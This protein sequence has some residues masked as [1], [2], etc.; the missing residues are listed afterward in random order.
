MDDYYE[1]LS[2]DEADFLIELYEQ[3][4]VR[5]INRENVTLVGIARNMKVRPSELADYMP[6]ILSMLTSLE[7]EIRQGADR[8]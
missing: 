1:I 6:Q 2:K 4:R 5:V 3:I 8:D 7:N